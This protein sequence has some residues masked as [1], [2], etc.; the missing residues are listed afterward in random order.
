MNARRYHNGGLVG[1]E[2]PA[3]L[4][5]G[6]MVLTKEQQKGMAGGSRQ[7][8]QNIRIVNAFDNSV[9][10]DYMGSAAGE[11]VIMNAVRRNQ[12]AFKQAV[13]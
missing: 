5:P 9:I 11:K 4:K 1:D 10:S 8:Q 6:E 13:A 3:I 2:V 12:N 7:A